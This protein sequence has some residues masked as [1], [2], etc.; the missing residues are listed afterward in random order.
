VQNLQKKHALLEA[1]V[2]SHQDRIE[3][4]RVAASQF[5]ERGHFDAD[6]IK[7]KEV[8]IHI[9]FK[10]MCIKN[11]LNLH[12]FPYIDESQIKSCY[13]SSAF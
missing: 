7:A 1:D 6:N 4:I 11:N 8:C 12:N 13:R 2:G 9:M 10:V 5:V 3:G